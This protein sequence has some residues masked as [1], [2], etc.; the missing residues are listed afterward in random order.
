M[1]RVGHA[2]IPVHLNAVLIGEKTV[3]KGCKVR[4]VSDQGML[5]TCDADGRILTFR[6][7]DLVDIH[8]LF[9]RPEGTRYLSTSAIV[10]H[11][12]ANG[13]GVKFSHPDAQLVNLIESYR[14]DQ[15][16]D[17][18]AIT[19][20]QHEMP[21]PDRPEDVV[22]SPASVFSG[23]ADRRQS[24]VDAGSRR[25]YYLGLLTLVMAIGI[26]TAGY[27]GTSGRGKGMTGVEALS[28]GY[29][30]ELPRSGTRPP[31]GS[32]GEMGGN[33]G[34]GEIVLK[35]DESVS[36]PEQERT[37]DTPAQAGVHELIP[38][39]GTAGIAVAVEMDG[40]PAAGISH[41]EESTAPSA[42]PPA[43]T[44]TTGQEHGPATASDHAAEKR[45]PWVINL[46]SS[47]SRS[48][49]DRFADKARKQGI[50]VE[51]SRVRLKGRMYFR[52]QLT[53]FQT[54]R[55]A[56]DSADPVKEALGLKD[57]WIFK[58]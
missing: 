58:P 27:L 54:A 33:S 22:I 30:S 50:P 16:R 46:L 49:A 11:V 31:P 47:P 36:T 10:R 48:E 52:V 1:E 39:R 45:G 29:H 43:M 5:L 41:E 9:P 7:G 21:E 13:I 40:A 38:S 12:D 55:L 15:S 32:D 20:H 2:R 26:I 42:M 18:D 51:L 19:T 6:D 17:P 53:G 23:H 57:V 25:Y 4:N 44:A 14:I 3:P 8:L 24:P 37:L 56:R 34:V 35:P 28:R